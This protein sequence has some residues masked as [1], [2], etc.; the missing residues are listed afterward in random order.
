MFWAPYYVLHKTHNTYN[1]YNTHK[2]SMKKL[3]LIY[4]FCIRRYEIKSS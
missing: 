4:N 1:A 2:D 3:R